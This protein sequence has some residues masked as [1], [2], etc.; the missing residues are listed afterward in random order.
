MV[1]RTFRPNFASRDFFKSLTLGPA[2]NLQIH[3]EIIS[4]CEKCCY[5]V[6]RV[7]GGNTINHPSENLRKRDFVSKFATRI[8]LY[9]V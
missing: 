6:I 1:P 5:S 8:N 7:F 9:T 4:V 2:Q 3:W